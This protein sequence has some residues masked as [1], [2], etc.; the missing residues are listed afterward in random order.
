[1]KYFKRYLILIICFFLAFIPLMAVLYQFDIINN[2]FRRTLFFI[3]AGGLFIIYIAVMSII[4]Y[5]QE[6]KK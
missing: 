4:I 3:I 6:K 1:M 5:R 2:P